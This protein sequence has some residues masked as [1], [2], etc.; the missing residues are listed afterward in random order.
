MHYML[1]IN[2]V[3]AFVFST[4]SWT[5]KNLAAAIGLPVD[6]LNRRI[7]FWISKV[8]DN[9]HLISVGHLIDLM[10]NP[11]LLLNIHDQ[12]NDSF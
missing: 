12:F 3:T 10:K 6:V 5:S 1:F 9:I 4:F 8:S 11:G 7:N 2:S